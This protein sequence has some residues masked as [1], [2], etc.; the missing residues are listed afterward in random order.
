MANGASLRAVTSGTAAP[1]ITAATV[2]DANAVVTDIFANTSAVNITALRGGTLSVSVT[3]SIAAGASPSDVITVYLGD[4][5]SGTNFDNIEVGTTGNPSSANE[6]RT[7]ST[8]AVNGLREARGDISVTVENNALPRVNLTAPAGP[9]ALGT[10]ITYSAEACNVGSRV[11]NPVSPATQLYI[12]APIPVGTRLTSLPSGAEYTTDLLTTAPLAANWSTA[13]PV[14]LASITRIRIPVGASIA[15]NTCA[16]AVTFDVTITTTNANTPIYE[17]VDLIGSNTLGTTVT[18]QSGDTVANR[19]DLNANFNE[20]IFGGTATSNQGFQLPTLL[21]QTGGVF[22]G[23]SGAPQAIGPTD[24]NDD[25]TNKSVTT[26]IATVAP[27]GSTTAAGTVYFRNTVQNTGNAN[28]TYTLTAPTV[29]T[30]FTVRISTDGLA[31]SN[32]AK[33][34][35]TVSGGG[36]TTLAVAF[37]SSSTIDV[38]VVAPSGQT[39]LTG[40]NTVIR[41]TSGIDNTQQNNTIDRLYTGFI[42]LD[43]SVVVANGTGVGGATD[44]VPGAVVTYTVRYTN[45]SEAG[46]ASGSVGLTANNLVITENGSAADPDGAGPLSANNWGATTTRLVI[47]TVGQEFDYT[48]ASGTTAGT[49]TVVFTPAAGSATDIYTDTIATLAPQAIGRFV[50][51]RTIN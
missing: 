47:S 41:A 22:I 33:A 25:F 3:L 1:T 45:V 42:R 50:F 8:A 28:D 34:W 2:T 12:Y 30:G 29:P 20:P 19:G 11:L 49:G 46:T 4:A 32:P 15:A 13:T 51:R 16:T 31:V 10:D 26:G 48:G 27:G 44:A 21:L 38:E 9:V 23:P 43:K 14:P 35:T 6:V 39:V 36:S 37:G 18:D 17:I 24:V 7:V 5:A 40:Y